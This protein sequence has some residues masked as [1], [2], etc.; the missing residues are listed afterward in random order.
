MPTYALANGRGGWAAH[1][2]AREWL[3]WLGCLAEL[4]NY[5]LANGWAGWV[6]SQHETVPE[7]G[8]VDLMRADVQIVTVQPV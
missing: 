8:S 7:Y 2:R 4:P 5:R 3:G 6:P 1:L